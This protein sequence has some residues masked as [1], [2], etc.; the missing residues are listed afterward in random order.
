MN[1]IYFIYKAD[2]HLI[3]IHSH[4]LLIS[5]QF[6]DFK[7]NNCFFLYD[8]S[9]QFYNIITDQLNIPAIISPQKA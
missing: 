6:A 4:N 7:L 9:D 2:D 1:F 5:S 3:A 8:N